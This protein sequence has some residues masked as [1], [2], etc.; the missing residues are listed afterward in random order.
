MLD[1]LLELK[2]VFEI[3]KDL[4]KGFELA[5]SLDSCLEIYLGTLMEH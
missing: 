2:L 3:V 4:E 1:C 5:C